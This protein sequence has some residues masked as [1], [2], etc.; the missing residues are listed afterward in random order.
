SS[1]FQMRSL[2][3]TLALV[4][5]TALA[6]KDEMLNSNRI[7]EMAAESSLGDTCGECKSVVHSFIAAIDD[8]AKLAEL[9]ILLSALCHSTAYESECKLIVSKID[10]IIK[11]LEP[12]LRDEE[13]VCKKMHLCH[14]AKLTNFHRIGL[15]YLK[16][17][18]DRIDGKG[19]ANDFVCDECQLAAIEFKKYIDDQNE[20]A[21]IKAFISE[22]L[23]KHIPKYS[24]ACDL[25]LE[26]FLPEIWQSLDA[27]LANP[28]V[29]CAQIGFCAKQA[30]LPFNKVSA[31]Q[32]AASFFKKSQ[33]LYTNSGD[34]VLMSCF[35][36]KVLVDALVFDLQEPAHYTAL[37]GMMR[38]WACPKLPDNMKDGC[39]DFLNMYAPTV[40]YMTAAQL[41]P[42]THCVKAGACDAVSVMAVKQMSKEEI[43]SK[44]C[45][46]CKAFSA[47][48]KY[49]ITQPDFVNDLV[50]GVNANVCAYARDFSAL[51]ENLSTS[52]IPLFVKRV[53]RLLE[54]NAICTKIAHVC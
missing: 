2:L 14:N 16:S 5:C 8:P 34:E 11:R 31:K 52:Y 35:E 12:Y 20:R 13:A 40:V 32:T 21:A 19:A 9:K 39:L 17:A 47:F 37:A 18:A 25:M 7:P 23:C 53:T 50:A 10:V 27:L 26:E 1:Q 54:T 44:K 38:D 33:H 15:L 43:N 51:C 48:M 49:E 24:G 46:A 41:D 36:C 6:H 29:A 30:G 4:A 22:N 45:D 3:V 42:D 28:K